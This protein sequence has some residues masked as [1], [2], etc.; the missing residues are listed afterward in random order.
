MCFDGVLRHEGGG[1]ALDER[2]LGERAVV[3]RHAGEGQA[4][5]LVLQRVI[6]FVGEDELGERRACRHRV[7]EEKELLLLRVVVGRGVGRDLRG[8]LREAVFGLEQAQEL[9]LGFACRKRLGDLRLR[10]LLLGKLSEALDVRDLRFRHLV[11]LQAADL[12]DPPGHGRRSAR[13][14]APG[15]HR[16]RASA[17]APPL[18]ALRRD[19]AIAALPRSSVESATPNIAA[20]VAASSARV[21]AS[22]MRPSLMG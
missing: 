9:Q 21:P 3:V 2:R 20:T 5:L 13:A 19:P 11:E 17:P 22:P 10:D 16:S 18:G 15:A 8:D 1:G 7:T 4:E 14:Q 6:E 12:G